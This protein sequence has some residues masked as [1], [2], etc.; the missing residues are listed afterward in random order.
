MNESS[1]GSASS[2]AFGVVSV[3]DFGCLNRYAVIFCCF[4]LHFPVD[5]GCR[6]SFPMLIGHVCIFFGKVSIKV[7][8][9]FLVGLFVFLLS[10]FV[11]LLVVF[12]LFVLA[13]PMACGRSQ[14]RD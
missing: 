12:R 4:H 5:I 9:H 8:A 14:A 13:A 1:R 11:C 2:P 7:Y 3:L 6:A 10:F